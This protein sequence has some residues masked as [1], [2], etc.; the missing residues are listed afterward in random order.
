[1]GWGGGGWQA[2][3][4]PRCQR[5][6]NGRPGACS[7]AARS[8]LRRLDA[9][10]TS[11]TDCGTRWLACGRVGRMDELASHRTTP[12]RTAWNPPLRCGLLWPA[13]LAHWHTGTLAHRHTWL[14]AARGRASRRGPP[15]ST[16]SPDAAHCN[17]RHLA[18]PSP[19][20]PPNPEGMACI[21]SLH[22]IR[23]S[24]TRYCP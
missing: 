11:T 14:S 20:T 13:C 3:D 12:H 4:D 21:I 23:S 22:P 2:W 17:S 5:R 15:L 16:L 7:S 18:W 19:T 24:G 8:E 6:V 1:M 9:T 10:T